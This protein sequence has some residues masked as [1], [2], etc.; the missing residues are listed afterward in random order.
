MS[1]EISSEARQRAAY[2]FVELQQVR[3]GAKS[4]QAY[5]FYGL[6]DRTYV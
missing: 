3:H 4:S 2:L 6:D 5:D 1:T